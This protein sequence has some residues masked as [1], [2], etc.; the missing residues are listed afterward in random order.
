MKLASRTRMHIFS[1]TWRKGVRTK[2]LTNRST[3]CYR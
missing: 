2:V 3:Q 1:R